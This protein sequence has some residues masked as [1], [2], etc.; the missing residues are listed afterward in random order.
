VDRYSFTV[1]DFHHRLLAGLPAHSNKETD[2]ESKKDPL[3]SKDPIQGL[4]WPEIGA[5]FL[6]T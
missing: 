1:V 6:A 3:D 2:K 5:A 4:A